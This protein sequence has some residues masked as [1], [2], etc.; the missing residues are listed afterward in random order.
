MKV[1]V[2]HCWAAD[3]Y[4][5]ATRHLSAETKPTDGQVDRSTDEV[6]RC[7]VTQIVVYPRADGDVQIDAVD[8]M[9]RLLNLPVQI[10]GGSMVAR[11]GLEPPTLRL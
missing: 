7:V 8:H 4:A 10:V 11:G 9:E 6:L 5:N 3:E 2:P 1:A